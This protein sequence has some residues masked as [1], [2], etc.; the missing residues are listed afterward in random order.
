MEEI[1]WTTYCVVSRFEARPFAQAFWFKVPSALFD[2]GAMAV[3]WLLLRAKG[4][5]LE[6]ILIYAWSPLPLIEFWGTGHNDSI[7]I[8]FI[9]LALAAAALPSRDRNGAVSLE[10]IAV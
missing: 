2:L 5:P 8:F 3:L 7:A 1:E 4:I 10:W 9:L 6:R